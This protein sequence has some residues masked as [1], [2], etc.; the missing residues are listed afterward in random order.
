MI[1]WSTTKFKCHRPPSP[2]LV[3]IPLHSSSALADLTCLRSYVSGEFFR[4]ESPGKLPVV[5]DG[6]VRMADNR[7]H[8]VPP[9]SECAACA[10]RETRYCC[11]SLVVVCDAFD[12]AASC[13]MLPRRRCD[14]LSA[15]KNQK[16]LSVALYH[17]HILFSCCSCVGHVRLRV[18]CDLQSLVALAASALSERAQRARTQRKR[19]RRSDAIYNRVA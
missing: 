3:F 8:L 15:S 5:M 13:G 12:K 17:Q 2:F 18:C 6:E 4:F 11:V 19:Q 14:A 7:A 9:H 1:K 10:L 16:P